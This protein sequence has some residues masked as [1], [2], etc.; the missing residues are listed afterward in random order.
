MRRL[1]ASLAV[2]VLLL[3]AGP[4][5]AA[6][7]EQQLLMAELRMLQLQQ[8]QLQQTITALAD[9][10]KAVSGKMDEQAAAG[11]KALAD[12]RLL[13]EGMTDNVRIL[14]EKADD[15]NV[16][17]SSMSQELEALRQTIASQA[18]PAAVP[19]APGDTPPEAPGAGAAEPGAAAASVATPSPAAAPVPPPNVSPQRTYDSAYSDYTGGQYDLAI[20]GFETFLKFFPRHTL[21]DE[22]QLNIGNA[23]YAAGKYREA[24]AAYQRVASDYP[25]AD[26]SV[27]EAYYKMGLSYNWLKQP[28]LARKALETVIEKF[29]EQVSA[30]TLARQALERLGKLP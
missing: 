17:L 12:Q 24:I 29:P 9:T 16:R 21:A 30:A 8:Q 22:A 27:A 11:R 10:L 15:T 20:V 18:M 23:N 14:R 1:G 25:T 3:H 5:D 19:A 28:D 4:A 13:V 7:K 6:N 2:A 26:R